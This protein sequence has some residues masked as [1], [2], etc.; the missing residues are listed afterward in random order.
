[1]PTNTGTAPTNSAAGSGNSK[2][3]DDG[4][5]ALTHPGAPHGWTAL[6]ALSLV[7]GWARRRRE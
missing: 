7:V 1:M 5:C 3:G 6:L 4:G 2:D